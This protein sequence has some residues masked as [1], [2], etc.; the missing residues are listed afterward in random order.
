MLSSCKWLRAPAKSWNP[1]IHR[2]DRR[3]RAGFDLGS[4]GDERMDA[5]SAASG[6]TPAPG[7]GGAGWGDFWTRPQTRHLIRRPTS[8]CRPEKTSP[9]RPQEN[10]IF[11]R[12]SR[13]K[14]KRGGPPRGFALGARSFQLRRGRCPARQSGRDP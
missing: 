11:I 1:S 2:D 7:T 10:V 14:F 9:H 13:V 8:S 5:W 12:L 6:Y 4:W 3:R